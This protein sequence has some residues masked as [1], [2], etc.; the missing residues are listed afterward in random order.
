LLQDVLGVELSLFIASNG[1]G[2]MAA[3]LGAPTRRPL[4]CIGDRTD[5]DSRPKGTPAKS[6]LCRLHCL[7]G[8]VRA[9]KWLPRRDGRRRTL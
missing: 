2:R 5:L 4:A 1:E 3:A 7:L 6:A 9:E 8:P